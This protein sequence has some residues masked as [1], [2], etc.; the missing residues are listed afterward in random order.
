[1]STTNRRASSSETTRHFDAIIIGAGQAGPS[2]AGRLNDA[3]M[4]VAIIERHLVGGDLREHRV[5]ADED[6][7][8]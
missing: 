6:A 3:G 4:R 1:V 7:D 2:L 8:R 5:Q